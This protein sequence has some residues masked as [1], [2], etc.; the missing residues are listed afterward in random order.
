MREVSSNKKPNN[1][2]LSHFSYRCYILGESNPS[3]SPNF[4]ISEF[5]CLKHVFEIQMS[6]KWKWISNNWERL[7]LIIKQRTINYLQF[8]TGVTCLDNRIH[9]WALIFGSQNFPVWHMFL[10]YRCRANENESQRT[11]R[12]FFS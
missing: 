10:K 9:L 7:L 6:G 4:W 5:P 11:E 2:N 3:L 8:L 12:G 1:N